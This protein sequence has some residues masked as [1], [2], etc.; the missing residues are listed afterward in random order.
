VHH[1]TDGPECPFAFV[2][3]A[4]EA[5]QLFSQFRSVHTSVG[6]FPLN[7]YLGERRTPLWAEKV[8]ARSL[9]WHLLI[10]ARK[11]R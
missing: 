10:E 4:G 5:R 1:C 11:Q 7:K 3:S 6:H 9:G 8:L 2:Y